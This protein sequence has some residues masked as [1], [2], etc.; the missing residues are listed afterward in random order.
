[1]L[2]LAGTSISGRAGQ[3]LL[4]S[5]DIP[6]LI[7]RSAEEYEHTAIWLARAHSELAAIREKIIRNRAALFDA[8]AFAPDFE[9]VLL[10]MHY[11]QR[12]GPPPQNLPA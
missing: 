10:E 3:S 1:M 8:N 6:E 11:R 4:T 9:N 5:L 7:A 12:S 2:T